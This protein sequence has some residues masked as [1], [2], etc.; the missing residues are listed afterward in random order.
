MPKF[1]WITFV[2]GLHIVATAPHPI[3]KRY[4]PPLK[5]QIEAI[6]K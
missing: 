3:E 5:Q 2:I 6:L 4:I 1:P